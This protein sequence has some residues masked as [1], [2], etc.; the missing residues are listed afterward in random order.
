M[1]DQWDSMKQMTQ[2]MSRNMRVYKKTGTKNWDARIA[3]RDL[4]YQASGLLK[5]DMQFHKERHAQGKTK[6]ELLQNME[7]E[8]AETIAIALFAAS[9][10]GLDVGKGFQRMLAYDAKKISTRSKK[11]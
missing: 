1:T 7:T 4:A 5:L 11:T 8:L 2:A 10:L 6:A 3:L 9:E